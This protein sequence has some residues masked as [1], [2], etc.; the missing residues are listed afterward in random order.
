[1]RV[2]SYMIALG[3]SADRPITLPT[4]I[5]KY[6]AVPTLSDRGIEPV[7]ISVPIPSIP[8]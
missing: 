3:N 7:T 1:M 6:P 8:D 4:R 2:I 5:T